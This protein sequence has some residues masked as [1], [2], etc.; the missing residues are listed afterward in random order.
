MLN[1]GIIGN[2][3]M[4]RAV[5]ER[6]LENGMAPKFIAA[7]DW[8]NNS[9]DLLPRSVPKLTIGEV[10]IPSVD[11]LLF[12]VSD[13]AI[14]VLSNFISA[15]KVNIHFAGSLGLD[16]FQND[17]G[18]GVIWPIQSISGESQVHWDN[19]PLVWDADTDEAKSYTLQLAKI[20]NSHQIQEMNLEARQKLH[21]AAVFI[22]NFTNALFVGAEEI[23]QDKN[24]V[25]LLLPLLAHT[26]LRYKGVDALKY[27]TGPASRNDKATMDKQLSSLHNYPDLQ[28]IYKSISQYI[29]N[30]GSH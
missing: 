5:T 9:W 8:K 26:A 30:K 19:I 1:L 25:K 21:L 6:L 10:P 22:S 20:L 23:L 11:V 27:Q 2:G 7:R 3:R 12:C 17:K 16:E 4:A 14:S 24:Q 28:E 29:L 13:Y 18:K 15:S